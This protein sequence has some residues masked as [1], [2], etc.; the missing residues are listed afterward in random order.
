MK[1]FRFPRGSIMIWTLLMGISL[2]V[3]F[4]FFSMRLNAGVASQRETMEYLNARLL[5]E[6][7]ADYLENLNLTDL[8]VL[9]DDAD[10]TS[11]SFGEIT[12]TLTND[13]SEITGMVEAKKESPQFD[14]DDTIDIQWN[15]CSQ[16]FKAEMLFV[17]GGTEELKLSP[18]PQCNSELT[19]EYDDFFTMMPSDPFTL[20]SNGAPFYYRISNPS[21]K[22]IPGN[23][24]QLNLQIPLS[25]RKKVSVNRTFTPG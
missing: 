22:S 8:I 14:I 23:E 1:T 18:D 25:A 10:D 3:V 21:G 19:T 17:S 6:S 7:Y 24:W 4:F 5:A 16:N 12:G 2:A 9:R 15:L 20:K 11:L 13:T